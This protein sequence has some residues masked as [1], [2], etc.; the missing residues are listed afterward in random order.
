MPTIG[1]KSERKNGK[2]KG[3]VSPETMKSL[4]KIN[5]VVAVTPVLIFCAAT[6]IVATP[7]K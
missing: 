5:S 1:I 7:A 3:K 2:E 6:Y 4:K